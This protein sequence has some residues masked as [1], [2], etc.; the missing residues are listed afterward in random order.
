M[1]LPHLARKPIQITGRHVALGFVGFF[2]VIIGVNVLMARLAL[3]SFG[4][5]VVDNSYVASQR[6]N[7]WL[8]A[9]RTQA[10][11]GWSVVI[12]RASDGHVTVEARSRDGRALEGASITAVAHHPLGRASDMPLTFRAG[13]RG[14]YRSVA[15]LPPGRWQVTV[16]IRH[17]NVRHRSVKDMS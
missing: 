2:A 4:G 1:P 5:T 10:A 9:A 11:L 8:A 14:N 15:P 17:G 13:D 3:S 6:Y 16:Q 7:G 12:E